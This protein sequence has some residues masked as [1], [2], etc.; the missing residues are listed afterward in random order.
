MTTLLDAD[1][2]RTLDALVARFTASPVARLEAWVFEDHAARRDAEQRLQAAGIH[3]RIRSAYKPLLHF[4]LEEYPPEGE[5]QIQLPTQDQ[6]SR[7]RLEAYPLAGLYPAHRFA[8]APGDAALAYTVRMEGRSHTVFAPNRA[9]PDHL[10]GTTLSPSGWL[11]S[12]DAAGTMLEDAPLETEHEALFAAGMAAILA[13]P[14]P[15]TP[16]YFTTLAID[17]AMPGIEHALP[18]HDEVLSTREAMHEDFYFSI[19]EALKHRAGRAHADRTLQPGQIVPDIRA[20]D[21]PA[22]LRI[23]LSDQPPGEYLLPGPATLEDADRPLAPS[24]IDAELARLG[25]APILFR[26]VQ[27]RAIP[28]RIIDGPAPAVVI[29]AAQ[30]ANE[31]S[32][33][34]GALRAA[35]RM[36]ADGLG[37]F[38]VIPCD[39]P[40]GYALHHRLR[41]ANPRHM[42][43]AARYTALGD[44]LESRDAPP[45][46]ERQARLDA[47]AQTGARL[48]INLHGYPAH[49]WTRPFS[50]Y[51]PRGF[52]LWSIP[53][54]FFLI[55]RH[56]AGLAAQTEA[57][58]QALA[59]ELATDPALRALNESQLATWQA[60]AGEIA[61]AVHS[62]I[63]CMIS[64]SVRPGPALQLIT[65]YPDETIYG[66]AFQLA[67]T[68]Q[69]RATL[70]ATRLFRAMF[71]PAA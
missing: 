40:D 5:V 52:E 39:N 8:F 29:T 63:P 49:E 53:K 69:M 58:A 4:F 41:A 43:H 14:W 66:P 42:H 59:A 48:H 62:A 71:P 24:Q 3:A 67:H 26:S 70:A 20:F 16:P 44:D 17:A 31:T 51:L 10:G 1:F 37:T 22:R 54:G 36:A 33:V 25:G 46:Y 65:E 19:L 18:Y 12:Y 55:F 45:Y 64:E 60:H 30:H 32:G 23:T 56:A 11:R 61:F 15:E 50:G 68:T 21:G 38:A 7:W 6:P 13:H 27:G 9:R 47:I 2:P 35:H 28:G 34:I 57:F